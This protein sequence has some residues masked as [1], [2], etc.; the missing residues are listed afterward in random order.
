VELHRQIYAE[1]ADPNKLHLRD[2]L[3][4]IVQ[5][6]L[7]A[8]T[9]YRRLKWLGFGL[10]ILL[11]IWLVWH[12][13]SPTPEVLPKPAGQESIQPVAIPPGQ[14]EPLKSDKKEVDPPPIAMANPAAFALNRDFEVR[15][16]RQIRAMG[17]TA[18]MTSPRAGANFTIQKGYVSVH[19]RGT[20]AAD[21]DTAQYP[22][23]L[24]IYNNQPAPDRP[25]FTVRPEIILR[26][27]DLWT[28]STTQRLRLQPGLYYFT[29]E[30]FA[31]D[32]LIF[33]GKF[34]VGVVH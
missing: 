25:Q 31:D 7:P 15:L 10:V 18:E 26:N 13:Q 11:A 33:V 8:P 32:D 27:A 19:F 28:F 21:N 4:E 3:H 30:R 5:A 17:G 22:L 20:S 29:I 2:L 34:T 1:L 23:I 9:K 24:K 16:G 12:W 6:P 14:T